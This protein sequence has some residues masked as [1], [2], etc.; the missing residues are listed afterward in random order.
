MLVVDQAGD[1]GLN[2]GGEDPDKDVLAKQSCVG[3]SGFNKMQTGTDIF[4][5]A[6]YCIKLDR[7][8]LSY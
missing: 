6:R 8:A 1:N 3:S 7:Q 5:Q 2:D 4:G